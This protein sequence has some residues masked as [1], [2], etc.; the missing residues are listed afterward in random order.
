MSNVIAYVH[1][2]L[3]P[4]EANDEKLFTMKL[5]NFVISGSTSLVLI[6][7][8]SALAQEFPMQTNFYTTAMVANV[9]APAGAAQMVFKLWGAGG[10]GGNAG[11]IQSGT[12]G[13]GAFVQTTVN[14]TPGQTY[15]IVVGQGG[16]YES[17]VTT[18]SSGGGAGSGDAA[19][20]SGVGSTTFG[21]LSGAGGQGSSVFYFNG[22]NYIMEAVA[23]GGG[24][25][26]LG[27]GGAG[28]NPGESGQPGGQGGSYGRGVFGGSYATNATTTGISE[29][30]SADG[31]GGN[32]IVFNNDAGG[33]GGGGYGGG[34]AG[35]IPGNNGG[36]GGG[37]G[38]YGDIIVGGSA[39]TAGETNDLDYIF[40]AGF[41]GGA[42]LGLTGNDGLAIV[43]FE[44]APP[45]LV[46]DFVPGQGLALNFAGMTNEVYIRSIYPGIHDQSCVRQL[47]PGIHQ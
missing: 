30:S 20:G 19:G 21:T 18:P 42:G 24:G 8:S 7:S 31:D 6:V 1:A 37:G 15:T 47:D 10:G 14:V 3:Q 35:V 32:A 23:G 13:G 41:G 36:G 33:G 11:I 44:A 17:V 27:L 25:G 12:G 16:G 5:V 29:L 34:S 2:Q 22:T 26:S 40:P 9:T 46:A 43:I 28:G 39:Q 38:S 45:M 4:L